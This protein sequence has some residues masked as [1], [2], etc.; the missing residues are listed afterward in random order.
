MF[1]PLEAYPPLP[2]LQHVP[3]AED[4]AHFDG[5][6]LTRNSHWEGSAQASATQ[7]ANQQCRGEGV[8][9]SVH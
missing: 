5:Q 7:A 3:I 4:A 2:P 8:T 9:A 6:G 1:S